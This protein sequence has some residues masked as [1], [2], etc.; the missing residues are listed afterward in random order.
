MLPYLY[1]MHQ[2]FHLEA[3]VYVEFAGTRRPPIF[4]L[5]HPSRCKLGTLH[6][7]IQ[8]EGAYYF[9]QAEDLVVTKS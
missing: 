6:S 3:S 4:L 8:T 1:R 2:L 5:A 7:Q 9:L